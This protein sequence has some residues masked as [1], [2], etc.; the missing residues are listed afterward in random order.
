MRRYQKYF[1]FEFD[2]I[3]HTIVLPDEYKY[4]KKYMEKG[5]DR[6]LL[7]KPSKGK[8][9]EGIFFVKNIFDVK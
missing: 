8:G 4:F 9:G 3:P 1:P 7:A 2:F 6:V 5:K